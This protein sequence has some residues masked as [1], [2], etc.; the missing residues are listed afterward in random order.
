MEAATNDLN[1][2]FLLWYN[3]ID[4]V[5]TLEAMLKLIT[6]YHDKDF[7]ML[8]PGCT[9]ENLTKIFLHNSTDN[10]FYPVTEREKPIWENREDV[11]GGLLIVF[12]RKAV[13]DEIFIRKSTYICTPVVGLDVS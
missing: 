11:V 5:T 9:S 4:V 13:V 3:N 2:R 1:Q 6:F 10:R 12:K 8:K 7:D